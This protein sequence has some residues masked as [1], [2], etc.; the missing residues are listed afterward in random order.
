M[1]KLLFVFVFIIFSMSAGAQIVLNKNTHAPL[2]G[3][4][5]SYS[6]VVFSDPGNSG[7]NNVWDLSK[8]ELT[9][10]KTV[11]MQYIADETDAQKFSFIPNH[12]LEES[13]NK[14]F[15]QITDKSYAITGFLNNDFE[16][17]YLVPLTRMVYPFTYTDIIEGELKAIAYNVNRT[18][19][20][21]SGNYKIVADAMGTIILPN[22]KKIEV[23]RVTQQ[24]TSVQV[25]ACSEVNI[26]SVKYMWYA[27]NE[28]YPIMTTIIQQQR[29]C[30]G[31]VDVTEETWISDRYLNFSNEENGG[32]L[33]TLFSKEDL[34]LNVFP[35]PFKESTQISYVLPVDSDVRLCVYDVTGNLV[36]EIQPKSAN[37]AGLYS[38]NLANSDSWIK[39]GLYFINLE[40]NGNVYSEKIICNQ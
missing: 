17:N 38:F 25:S 6:Q 10:K 24:S 35:N 1:G 33:Q 28:R 27:I 34:K 29:Y 5:N 3:D 14:F 30:T 8:A 4:I 19:T 11:S 37:K 15:H 18:E 13:G 7:K 39:P 23:L 20:D 12:V 21:I 32:N 2:S 9:G 26:E 22:G 31:K 36:K 16:I 40:I